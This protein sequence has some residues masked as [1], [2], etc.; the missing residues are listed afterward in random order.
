MSKRS[1]HQKRVITDECMIWQNQI[2]STA[3]MVS[4]GIGIMRRV[5]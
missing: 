3:K 4:K 5:N 1:L 2:D